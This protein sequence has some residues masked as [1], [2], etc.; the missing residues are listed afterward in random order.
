MGPAAPGHDHRLRRTTEPGPG[1]GGRQRA[2]SHPAG[3]G[4]SAPG[5]RPGEHWSTRSAHSDAPTSPPSSMT[6]QDAR[7]LITALQED[8]GGQG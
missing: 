8:T 3:R 7:D 2:P 5:S 4:R 6:Y 1:Q